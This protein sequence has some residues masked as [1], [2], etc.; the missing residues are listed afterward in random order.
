MN[1]MAQGIGQT[2]TQFGNR[3]IYKG[4][5]V[6][7]SQY[8]PGHYAIESPDGDRLAWVSGDGLAGL[9]RAAEFV[10]AHLSRKA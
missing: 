9:D 3:W 10:D 5:T 6:D 7:E 4:Y 8:Y 1:Q 2:R